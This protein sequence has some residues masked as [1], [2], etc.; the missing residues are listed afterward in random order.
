[1]VF[2]KGD[3]SDMVNKILDITQ[4]ENL[5]K[6]LIEASHKHLKEHSPAVIGSAYYNIITEAL[7]DL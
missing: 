5:E 3:V 4:N 1:M 7:T 6:Q 2:K